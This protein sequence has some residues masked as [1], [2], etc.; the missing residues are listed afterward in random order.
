MDLLPNQWLTEAKLGI[1]DKDLLPNQWLT[2][3]KLGIIAR[4]NKRSNKEATL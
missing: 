4:N 3:A 2:E 1:I